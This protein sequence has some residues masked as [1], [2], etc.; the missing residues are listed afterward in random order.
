M[1]VCQMGSIVLKLV[2]PLVECLDLCS[3]IALRQCYHH[4]INR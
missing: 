2:D 1:P 3:S 4:R